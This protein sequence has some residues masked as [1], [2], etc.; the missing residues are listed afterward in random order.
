MTLLA[1]VTAHRGILILEGFEGNDPH[2]LPDGGSRI[3]CVVLDTKNH[4]GVS[5]EALQILD[6]IERGDDDL[7]DVDWWACDD[8]TKAFGWI[9]PRQRLLSPDHA[10]VS[11]NHKVFRDDCTVIPNDSPQEAIEAID[12]V[13]DS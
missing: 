1:K 6:K 10:S 11:R 7:G 2:W 8:G 12:E 5:E 9:G 13:L 3:G 4:L